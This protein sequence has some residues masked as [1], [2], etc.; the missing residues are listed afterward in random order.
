MLKPTKQHY[1]LWRKR[2][3]GVKFKD[4]A[5]EYNMTPAGV[6]LALNR[7]EEWESWPRFRRRLS[8]HVQNV[9]LFYFKDDESIFDHPERIAAEGAERL[10]K[11]SKA[12]DVTLKELGAALKA[13]GYPF[14]GTGGKKPK[15]RAEWGTKNLD[16]RYQQEFTM[17]RPGGRRGHGGNGR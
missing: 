5:A 10:G 1:E 15:V 12:K 4:L 13:E 14:D 8:G 6:K 2:K 11:C 3:Q 16:E 7:L 9:L 17:F